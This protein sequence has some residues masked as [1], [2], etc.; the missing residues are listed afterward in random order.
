VQT[1]LSSLFRFGPF[2]VNSATGELLKNGNR[3]KL[4]E[5]PFRL[6]VV[7]LENAGEIVTREELRHRIWQDDIFVDFDS[8]LRVA[9]GK[10]REALGDDAENPRYVETIPKR[11]YRFLAPEAYPAFDPDAYPRPAEIAPPI[12]ELVAHESTR[13]RKW[14]LVSIL[15]LIVIGVIG[16][17]GAVLITSH[18]FGSRKLLTER[19]TV[20]LADFVNSTGDP[21]F[22]ETLRQGLAVQ[23]AQSPFLSLIPQEQIQQNLSLMRKPAEARLTPEVA[24]EIC[25]RTASAAVLDGSITRLGTQYVVGLRA[26]DCRS[27]EV[28]AEEQVQA[29]RKED[30]LNALSEIASRFRT[31][32][33][34]S[35]ATV[36]K[37][38]TPLAEATTPSLEALKAYSTGLKVLSTSGE[39]AAVPFFQR[40]TELDPQFATAYAYL[41]LMYGAMGESALSADSTSRA[42]ELRDRASDNERFFIAASYD[43]RVTGNLERAQ[44]TCEAWAETYPREAGPHSYLAGFI[45]PVSG[46]YAKALDESQKILDVDP[47]SAIGYL[48]RAYTYV[49]LQ[50]LDD[51]ESTLQRASERK[52]ANPDSIPLRYDIAFLRGDR[53][54]MDRAAASPPKVEGA[55]DWISVHQGF[56]LAYG[57]RLREAKA[58]SQRAVDLAEQ[59]TNRERAALFESGKAV[60]EAF[61]GEGAAAKQDATA[62]IQMSRGREVEYGAALALA[63]AGDISRSRSMISDMETRFPEDTSVRFS[64]LPVLRGVV[65]LKLGDPAKTIEGLQVAVPYELGLHRSTIHGLFGA[66]YPVFV[67]GEAYLAEQRGAEA[68]AEFQKILD[69]RGIVASDPVGALAHLQLGRAYVLTGDRIKARSAYQDFFTLWN[70]ADPGIQLLTQARAEYAKL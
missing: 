2:Q 21:V 68:A 31:H 27:G 15:L 47:N 3:V 36:Q 35:L 63:L 7:L 44:Q 5:Q 49:Y 6:L 26:K 45:Y 4:Q 57:G 13:S 34:E 17:I 28:L 48:T 64:Y 32:L 23:L 56:A 25:E 18:S 12:A 60:W 9:V 19:D 58:V 8:S 20:V 52:L 70:E 22:D 62:A 29:V 55:A 14:A 43:G 53:A 46:R 59:A 54:E 69:H 33:G 50:R 11:G 37:H 24:H 40:A 42:Y 30:V 10:L 51:A 61:Y 66:L 39:P 1:P 16:V 41:G 65:A 67:R 38:N